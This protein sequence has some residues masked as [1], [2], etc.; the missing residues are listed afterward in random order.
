MHNEK[1]DILS[2]MTSF[3]PVSA[4]GTLFQSIDRRAQPRRNTD[5]VLQHMDTL[6][7]CLEHVGDGVI[8]ID[9]H[10]RVVHMTGTAHRLLETCK[11]H[12]RV[13]NNQ[14]IFTDPDKALYLRQFAKRAFSS[15]DDCWGGGR[16]RIPSSSSDRPL[17]L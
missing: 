12:I 8:L 3:S 2:F 16:S 10:L 9:S 4:F 7:A 13:Q 5:R 11:D 6:V 1:L 14:L 15:D 17:N